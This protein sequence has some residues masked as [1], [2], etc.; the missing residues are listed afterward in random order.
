M[1]SVFY[2]TDKMYFNL[3]QDC[4][5]KKKSNTFESYLSQSENDLDQSKSLSSV[6]ILETIPSTISKYFESP[7]NSHDYRGSSHTLFK[8]NTFEN[9]E[10]YF[11]CNETLR[12]ISDYFFSNIDLIHQMEDQ[13]SKNSEDSYSAKNYSHFIKK[14]DLLDEEIEKVVKEKEYLQSKIQS[15]RKKKINL[16]NEIENYQKTLKLTNDLLKERDAEL[17]KMKNYNKA[18]QENVAYYERL[19][20]ETEQLKSSLSRQRDEDTPRHQNSS[21]KMPR[22]SQFD[23]RKSISKGIVSKIS[24]QIASNIS[25]L[26]IANNIIEDIKES[27][28]SSEKYQ[29]V[30]KV[31]KA[32]LL[33][34]L[35]TKTEIIK[36][37]LKNEKNKIDEEKK[38]IEKDFKLLKFFK[39]N[40]NYQNEKDYI[41]KSVSLILKERKTMQKEKEEINQVIIAIKCLEESIMLS[42]VNY[43]ETY[44]EMYAI[45]M[46]LDNKIKE[47]AVLLHKYPGIFKSI[48]E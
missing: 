29:N 23:D 37:Y 7:S 33:Q 36:N 22:N 9:T 5:L 26:D 15:Y 16:R 42:I 40:A 43:K 19:C 14:K 10:Y 30:D 28:K 38:N 27:V 24:S 44:K 1:S 6:S 46:K 47:L 20:K 8:D 32:N 35:K 12:K 45:C 48:I 17:E 39:D 11:N 25:P 18:L 2:D 4:E 41:K 3:N 31:E 13:Y 34:N 21:P